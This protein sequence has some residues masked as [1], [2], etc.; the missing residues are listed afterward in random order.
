MTT[1]AD[2]LRAARALI[3]DPEQWCQGAFA[4]DKAGNHTFSSASDAVQW[5]ALGACTKVGVDGYLL[6]RVSGQ[7][8]AEDINDH[9]GHE[10]VMLLFDRAISLAEQEQ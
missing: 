2:K 8:T 4:R 7:S 10:A 5:C 3:E 9:D 1:E 6:Q